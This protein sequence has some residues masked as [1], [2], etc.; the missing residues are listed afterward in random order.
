MDL[1]I[2]PVPEPDSWPQE[3]VEFVMAVH[4]YKCD[5]HMLTVPISHIWAIAHQLGYRRVAEPGFD[6]FAPE[7]ETTG[8]WS[9]YFRENGTGRGILKELQAITG[10]RPK[11]CR[12]RQRE[13]VAGPFC[14]ACIEKKCVA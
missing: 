12:C 6:V 5:N 3:L 14:R 2:S 9:R 11:M 10:P 4:R 7:P 1:R 13:A 8:Y